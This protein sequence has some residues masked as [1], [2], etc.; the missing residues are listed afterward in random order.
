MKPRRFLFYCK[1]FVV[2]TT[3]A[4]LAAW[5]EWR[6]AWRIGHAN[7]EDTSKWEAIPDDVVGYLHSL[8][9]GEGHS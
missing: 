8:M 2:M 7:L 4:V 1:L 5:R 6:I 3:D 9:D